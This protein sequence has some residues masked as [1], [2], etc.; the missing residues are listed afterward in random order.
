MPRIKND[1][2]ELL[3][4]VGKGKL[5][6]MS[7]E[8]DPNFATTIVSVSGGYPNNYQKGL[9]ISG[10]GEI[11]E[12]TLLFHSGTL[13]EDQKV[14]TNGGRVLCA[15]ALAPTLDEALIK[16]KELLRQIRFEG[17]YYRRDIGFEFI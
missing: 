7:V 6:E 15:T 2:V 16:S 9:E 17:M 12:S 13:Q 10:L 8:K 14:I 3:D 4:S 5:N 1:L 11:P